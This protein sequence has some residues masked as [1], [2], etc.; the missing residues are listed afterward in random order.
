M[1]IIPS[2]VL[3][4]TICTKEALENLRYKWPKE[5]VCVY[6]WSL[7]KT[8]TWQKCS[9]IGI[10][11]ILSLQ[12]VTTKKKISNE[13][14][15][16]PLCSNFVPNVGETFKDVCHSLVLVRSKMVFIWCGFSNTLAFIG[17]KVKEMLDGFY[18]VPKYKLEPLIRL[19]GGLAKKPHLS[20]CRTLA[21][22][23]ILSVLSNNLTNSLSWIFS[24]NLHFYMIKATI[25]LPFEMS[26]IYC[27]KMALISSWMSK[28][29]RRKYASFKLTGHYFLRR[30]LL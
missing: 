23:S 11:Q 8:C 29:F 1:K 5:M 7:G 25:F 21:C 9:Q 4:L 2:R 22:Y 27:L 26:Q 6:F 28:K 14:S 18:F 3:R 30:E 19:A 20:S 17:S 12:V 10:A 24:I 13:E 15:R 16:H